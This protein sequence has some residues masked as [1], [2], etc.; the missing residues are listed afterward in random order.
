MTKEEA[1][2]IIRYPVKPL[3]L[4]ALS[5]ANLTDREMDV[6][7]LRF[8]RGHTQEETA[9][10]MSCTVNGLQK[11]EREVIARFAR[12]ADCKRRNAPEAETL[13]ALGSMTD[14]LRRVVTEIYHLCGSE[15]ERSIV[16]GLKSKIP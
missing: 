11:W 16:R 13:E 12:Y 9:E 7:I 14:M 6:L 3:A 5:Y 2:R 15:K 1:K 10:E 4:V 8:M